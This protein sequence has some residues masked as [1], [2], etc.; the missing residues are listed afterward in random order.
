MILENI[1]P[2]DFL[3]CILLKEN[4]LVYD[5]FE[6]FLFCSE[7]ATFGRIRQLL[8][9]DGLPVVFFIIPCDCMAYQKGQKRSF[10]SLF[11]KGNFRKEK[12]PTCQPP[13]K[14]TS[15]FCHTWGFSGLT[16]FTS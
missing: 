16:P 9:I 10:A 14:T 13:I 8:T 6:I 7:A 11:K 15:D 12:N 5:I 1:F 3:S 4:F 2:T